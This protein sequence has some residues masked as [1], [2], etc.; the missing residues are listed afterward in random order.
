VSKS[1]K[2]ASWRKW[3]YEVHNGIRCVRRSDGTL[4]PVAKQPKRSKRDGHFAKVVL[5]K[6]V[7]AYAAVGMP[8]AV[9]WPLLVYLDYE[10]EGKPFPLS[11]V[12]AARYGVSR[13]SKRR[14][15][16]RWSKTGLISLRQ[17]GREAVE[18][19]MLV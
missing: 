6:A 13:W 4:T 18:V 16:A 7:E 2:A 8:G 1:G 3:P 11:N 10:A 17:K 19:K 9:L 15:L 5:D 14:A 12:L